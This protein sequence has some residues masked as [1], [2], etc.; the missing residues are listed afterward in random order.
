[1]V[2]IQQLCCLSFAIVR[3]TTIALPS[4]HCHCEAHMTQAQVMC[5]PLQCGHSLELY[6]R[7]AQLFSP[8]S[9]HHQCHDSGQVAQA[10]QIWAGNGGVDYHRKP[11]NDLTCEYLYISSTI[12]YTLS[13]VAVQECNTCFLPGHRQRCC[14]HS[15]YGLYHKLPQPANWDDTP[16]RHHCGHEAGE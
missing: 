10:P 12:Y 6:I 15:H 5:P 8:I 4:W 1:M 2:H 14:H 9:G 13:S 7:H 11:H 16:P 3:S